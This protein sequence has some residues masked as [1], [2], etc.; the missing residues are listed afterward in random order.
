MLRSELIRP[1]IK[2]QE[3][4]VSTR[5]IEANYRYLGIAAEL[6]NLFKAHIGQSRGRLHDALRDYEGDSLDYPV[7]RGLAAVLEARCEFGSAPAID[8]SE[9]RTMLFR[10]GP[11]TS[12]Q[13]LFNLVTREQALA[14]TA[15]LLVL[16][17]KFQALWEDQD[18]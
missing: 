11:V 13:D 1:R 8:P 16:Q 18:E 3:D 12:R 17:K 14:E 7:I 10:R 15:A 2:I 5:P 4:R 9:L 6:V